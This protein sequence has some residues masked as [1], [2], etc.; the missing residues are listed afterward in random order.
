[1]ER[2]H[3][4]RACAGPALV[5]QVIAGKAVD[6]RSHIDERAVHVTRPADWHAHLG[7][8]RVVVEQRSAGRKRGKVEVAYVGVLNLLN[9]LSRIQ[10]FR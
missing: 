5:I 4:R 3:V 10:N 7:C 8:P 6:D 2:H 1:M 9:F